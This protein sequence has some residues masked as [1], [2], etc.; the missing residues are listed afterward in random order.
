[1]AIFDMSHA[2]N[3]VVSSIP[4]PSI[5]YFEIG[6][7]RIYFYALCIMTG[8]IVAAIMTNYRLTRRGGEP[9]VVIDIS[10]LAVPFAFVGA[11]TFHVLT[12]MGDYFGPGENPWNPF[13]PGSVWA[14]W[15]G[16][17][18]IFG[19]LLGGA[20]GAWLG[21]KWTGIRFWS[22]ADALAPGLLFAQAIG[23]LGNWFNSELFGMPTDLPWGLEIS[24]SNPAF[25][26]GLPADTLF[27]PT[28]LYEMIWN[29]LGVVFLLWLSKRFTLQWGKLF[30]VYLMWYGAGRVVWESIRIDPSEIFFGIRV[31]V[32][33]ALAAIALGLI[34][35]LVQ[36][37]RHPGVEPSVYM[38]GRI[39][40]PK[41]ESDSENDFVDVSEPDAKALAAAKPK[42]KK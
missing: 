11:R 27:H 40:G 16:G 25:P 6:P 13:E 38:P 34:I 8:L 15:E 28:F 19:A 9:W 41:D 33:A 18:A 37:R 1:M 23:R 39:W 17:I 36:T 3:I 10:L 26:P 29:F 2:L 4:S 42:S 21:C 35:I 14:I 31:N 32:W 30:G 22:F 5:S 12:H 20:V 24:P 7:I